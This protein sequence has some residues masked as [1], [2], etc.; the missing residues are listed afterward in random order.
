MG[1]FA[2]LPLT[3]GVLCCLLALPLLMHKVPPNLFSM[4]YEPLRP[5][6]I[7]TFGTDLTGQS[8]GQN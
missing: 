7:Q 2:A 6:V 1:M 3:V 8:F 5:F 4:D